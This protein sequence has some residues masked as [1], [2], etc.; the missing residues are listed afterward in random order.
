[1]REMVYELKGLSCAHCAAKI[2]EDVGRLD[3]VDSAQVSFAVQKLN[4]SLKDE[5]DRELVSSEVRK[6]VH[7]TEPHVEVIDIKAADAGKT[8]PAASPGLK[9][10]ILLLASGIL[11][12]AVGLALGR[13]PVAGLVLLLGA[14]LTAGADVLWSAARNIVKGRVF[15]ENFLMSIA[16]AG[17]IATGQYTEAAAVMLFY[18]LGMIFEDLAVNRSRRSVKALLELKP[19]YANVITDGSI[20]RK[21]PAEVA[22]GDL[23]LVKPGE[24]IPL[25]GRIVEGDSYIDTSALTGESV[26]RRVEAGDRVF[27]GCI[28]KTGLLRLAVVNTFEDSEVSRILELVQNAVSKKARI[29]NFIT[30]FA[31]YYTPAVV[32]SAVLVAVLPPLLS[33]GF[34]F[35]TWLYRALIFL[36]VSCPCALVVSIPLTY[37]AGIGKAS[38]RGILVKGGNYLDVLSKANAVVF[39]KT[40]TL[41]RGVFSVTGV[42]AIGVTPERLL[43]YA[44]L[45]E[46]NS[47]HPIA[48]SI[49]EAL[50]GNVDPASIESVEEF[51]G[52]GVMA[53]TAE[54]VILAGSLDFLR[55]CGIEAHELP[56]KTGT[57]VYV[58]VDDRFLGKITVSD[59]LKPDAV[60]AVESL[61][62]AGIKNICMLTGDSGEAALQ[63]AGELKLDSVCANL[64]PHQKLEELESMKSR[65]EGRLIY[66]GDGINDAPVLARADAGV[67]MGALGSDAAIEASDIVLMTDEPSRLAEAVRIAR[68]TR[69]IAMQNIILALTVKVAVLA[70]GTTG[71][72]DMWEAVFADV[73]VTLLAVFNALRILRD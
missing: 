62:Q 41:T 20:V 13:Y 28:N 53:K 67:S 52:R 10:D 11:L 14:W 42:D 6:A 39:D 71:N 44:A 70:L 55:S 19:D 49:M 65:I 72:A 12:F 45:A 2:E 59:S 56:G 66:V 54:G 24:R 46:A 36:V 8:K 22:V 57:A 63:V 50:R 23:L 3:G 15:D 21:D 38:S 69:R 73:G 4:I 17:A 51:A 1:M 9:K 25:D 34:D 43:E 26:P 47:S 7:F 68:K 5:A 16:T 60:K 58:A 30:R 61:R 31:V 48:L 33:G 18:K 64:L 40:G 37:F 27:G 32:L 35:K 29:E